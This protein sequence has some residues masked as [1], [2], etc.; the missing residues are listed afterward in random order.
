MVSKFRKNE[1]RWYDEICVPRLLA[2]AK[3]RSRFHALSL[4]FS[5]FFSGGICRRAATRRVFQLTNSSYDMNS[6]LRI[7]VTL[8]LILIYLFFLHS[9]ALHN[10][11]LVPRFASTC[12]TSDW[13]HSF[14]R[15]GRNPS[16]NAKEQRVY[17]EV[18]DPLYKFHI[19][20]R[21]HD[22]CLNER[23]RICIYKYRWNSLSPKK[24]RLKINRKHNFIIGSHIF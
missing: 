10:E 20:W 14:E 6:T 22:V 8:A 24:Y 5:L 13:V 15:V 3:Y 7:H 23:K 16:D 9:R 11:V 12:D 18:A 21:I 19:L 2:F 1:F 17:C 4:S